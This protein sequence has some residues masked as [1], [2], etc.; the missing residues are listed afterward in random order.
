MEPRGIAA[1]LILRESAL[2]ERRDGKH[3]SKIFPVYT[4]FN[5]H[6]TFV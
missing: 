5:L 6:L 3:Y 2:Q 4:P 1:E